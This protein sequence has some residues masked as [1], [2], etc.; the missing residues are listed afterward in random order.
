M[1]WFVT[2]SKNCDGW[3][4]RITDSLKKERSVWTCPFLSLSCTHSKLMNSLCLCIL[5]QWRLS[6]LSILWFRRFRCS[7]LG[8]KFK[9]FSLLKSVSTEYPSWFLLNESNTCYSLGSRR[10]NEQG[11]LRYSMMICVQS[12]NTMASTY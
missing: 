7:G 6:S 2:S 4:G 3:W 1:C 11:G 5:S 12:W 10:N 9:C 8:W